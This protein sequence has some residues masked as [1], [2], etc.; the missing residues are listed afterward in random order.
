MSA[1]GVNLP[2]LIAQVITFLLFFGALSAILYKPIL[3]M[4]DQR[5]QR[6]KESLESAE[7]VKEETAKAEQALK[8]E[9]EKGRTEARA[10]VGQA[11]EVAERVREEARQQAKVEAEA[12]IA[13]ARSEAQRELDDALETLRG[14]FADLTV[15][16]A[17]RVIKASLDVNQHR[18]LIDEVVQQSGEFRKN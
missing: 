6:I 9:I 17:E 3:R 5:A 1:L 13:R 11:T 7:K 18:R 15:T 4:L 14:Q 16:A 2:G 8:A 12:I 10:I